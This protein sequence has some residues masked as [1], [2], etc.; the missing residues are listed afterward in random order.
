MSPV[1]NKRWVWACECGTRQGGQLGGAWE[2]QLV[3]GLCIGYRG[4]S[5]KPLTGNT[6]SL[7]VLDPN[8]VGG[9]KEGSPEEVLGRM[10]GMAVKAW[11]AAHSRAKGLVSTGLPTVLGSR[12]QRGRTSGR[13]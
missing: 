8:W 9:V 6:V 7:E 3:L 1:S 10:G 2:L 11:D 12:G 5:G 4:D 13:R